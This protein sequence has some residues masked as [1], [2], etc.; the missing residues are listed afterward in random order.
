MYVNGNDSVEREKH[1]QLCM[2]EGGFVEYVRVGGAQYT[3]GGTGF[4]EKH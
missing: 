1:R 2:R 4:K 3:G